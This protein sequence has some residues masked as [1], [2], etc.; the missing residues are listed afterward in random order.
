[1]KR[2]YQNRHWDTN[3]WAKKH[4]KPED[5]MNQLHVEGLETDI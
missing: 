1:M 2:H 4:W 3:Q 5:E